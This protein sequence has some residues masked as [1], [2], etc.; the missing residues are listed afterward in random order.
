M[1][2][3]KSLFFIIIVAIIVIFIDTIIYFWR[4]SCLSL[5]FS[6]F[7][8]LISDHNSFGGSSSPSGLLS[9]RHH[10][11]LPDHPRSCLYIIPF[12]LQVCSYRKSPSKISNLMTTEL[13][14]AHILNMNR[15]SLH[16]RS[17]RRIHL[18][19]LK[20]WLTKSGFAG[21]KSVWVLRETGPREANKVYVKDTLKIPTARQLGC[22]LWS[23]LQH[24]EQL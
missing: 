15:G 9:L 4:R 12:I 2:W 17:L 21:Q 10:T 3:I 18:S 22:Q 14:Y 8:C 7:T 24:M 16:T 5:R 23:H 13:F 20:Y 1:S 19:V 11:Q 6:V